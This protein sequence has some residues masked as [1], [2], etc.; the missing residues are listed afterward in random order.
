MRGAN[1]S[2]KGCAIVERFSTGIA[3]EAALSDAF[4]VRLEMTIKGGLIGK[5]FVAAGTFVRFFSSMDA[6]V[7]S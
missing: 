7:G 1:V 2:V 4:V 3:G 6:L 5:P